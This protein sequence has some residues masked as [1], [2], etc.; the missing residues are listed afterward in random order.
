[1]FNNTYKI[2]VFFERIIIYI[3]PNSLLNI[4]ILTQVPALTL[5]RLVTSGVSRCLEQGWQIHGRR[6]RGGTRKDFVATQIFY[7]YILLF[8]FFLLI[9]QR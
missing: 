6:A 5:H 3:Q 7:Y 9:N 8:I 2:S 4:I 1:M